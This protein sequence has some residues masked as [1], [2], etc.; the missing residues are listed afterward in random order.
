M[1]EIQ[2]FRLS[3]T[4]EIHE[5]PCNY[6]DGHNVIY[7]KDIE[8]VFPGV[9]YLKHGNIMVTKLRDSEGKR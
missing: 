7:W 1:E 6:L 8:V 4:T 5:I 3:G 9:Q 2:H